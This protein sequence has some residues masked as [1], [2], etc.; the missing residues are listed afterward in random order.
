MAVPGFSAD[1]SGEELRSSARSYLR[2]IDVWC[3]VTRTPPDQRVSFGGRCHLVAEE[4]LRPSQRPRS[5]ACV[6]VLPRKIWIDYFGMTPDDPEIFEPEDVE[7]DPDLAEYSPSE[8]DENFAYD[9]PS[10]DIA[11]P[12][13]TE[14][15]IPDAPGARDPD[16]LLPPEHRGSSSYGPVPRRVRGKKSEREPYSAMMLKKA[17][18]ERPREKQFEKELPWRMIPPSEHQGF[19]LAEEK[20]IQEHLVNKALTPLSLAESMEVERTVPAGRIPGSR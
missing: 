17:C 4:R 1:A 18:T 14:D 7:V 8:P 19:K 20:Q 2:Q 16:E 6:A 11:M 10:G 15:D 5:S 13:V 12:G 9:Y 3:K